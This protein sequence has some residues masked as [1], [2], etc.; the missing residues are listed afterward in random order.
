ME[1]INVVAELERLK[2]KQLIPKSTGPKRP[3]NG[4]EWYQPVYAPPVVV[5]RNVNLSA[6]GIKDKY[7]TM[8]FDKLKAYGTPTE[9]RETYSKAFKYAEHIR[10]HISKG[11]GLI[12]LG[13]VGTGKTSLAISI[14]RKAIDKGYNGY[15]ISMMS[16]LDTLLSLSKG[17][18]SDYIRFENRIRNTPLLVLDD[19]GAEYENKWVANKVD[20]IIADRVESCKATIITTNL[21]MKQIQQGYDSRIYDRLKGSS[22]VLLLRGES[23]RKPLSDSE[24]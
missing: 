2:R 21:T 18:T 16:L 13:P 15:L 19:F 22:F 23:K 1:P 8:T 12:L 17:E 20:S 14:L 5:E 10:D 4:Y 3:Q 24:I 6:Y 7:K 9:D 11:N